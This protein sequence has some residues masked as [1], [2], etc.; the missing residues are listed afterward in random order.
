VKAQ[1]AQGKIIITNEYSNKP[2]PLVATT[3]FLAEDGTLFR[4]VNRV[5]V[6]GMKDNT[7]GKVEALVIADAEGDGSNIGPSRF[8]IPGFVGTPKEGKF[9]AISEKAM[10]GG[11]TGGTGVSV[12]TKADI[13]RAQKEMAK[14]SKQYVTEQITG[15]LR[16]DNE[17]LIDEDIVRELVR[18]EASLSV[19]TMAEQFMYEM[20][21]HTKALVFS[22]DDVLAVLESNL[23]QKYH[24]YDAGKVKIQ[25]TYE[26]VIPDFDKDSIQM[27]AHGVADVVTTVDI[28]SFKEKILGKKHDKLLQI[29][30]NDYNDEI[31]KITIENVFPGFP[32]FI[33]NHISRFEFMTDISIK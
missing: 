29:M 14:E 2:Q 18:S 9:Y 12:V 30:E 21:I 32:G 22:E 6:P 25:I 27:V 26:D 13:E 23:A 28:E 31:E 20:V 15:L 4:L 3:R 10:T 19:D 5:T 8:S 16:P 24:Q 1:K 33:A 17:V 11:G 7:A